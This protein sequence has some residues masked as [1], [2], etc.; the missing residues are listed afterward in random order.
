IFVIPN[1]IVSLADLGVRQAS[2][3]YI[4]RKI[5]SIKDVLSSSLFL[6]L[7]TSVISLSIV[8]VYFSKGYTKE[9]GWL[10]IF[11]ALLS[12]PLK[13]LIVYLT[14]IMQ[15]TQKI[16]TINLTSLINFT[17]NLLGVCI[18]VWLF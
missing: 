4:G 18:L 8:L 17:I 1:L 12:I 6:W 15:G 2:A 5:Y 7:I 11:I 3:Y 10:L 16:G 13:L 14:G 9:Y